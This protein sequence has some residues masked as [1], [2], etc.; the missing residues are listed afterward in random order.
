MAAI[1]TATIPTRPAADDSIVEEPAIE[2]IADEEP[3]DKGRA[4]IFVSADCK[5]FQSSKNI[6]QN[7]KSEVLRQGE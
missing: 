1:K 3:T 6:F 5:G 2:A 7:V 4:G